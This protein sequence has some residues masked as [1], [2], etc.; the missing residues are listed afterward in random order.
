VK[1]IKMDT[2]EHGLGVFAP[3]QVFRLRQVRLL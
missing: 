1:E 3:R 2:L